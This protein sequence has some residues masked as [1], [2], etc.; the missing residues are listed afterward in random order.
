MISITGIILIL[1]IVMV[2]AAIKG[3]IDAPRKSIY[4]ARKSR[5][6]TGRSL[7]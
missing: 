7:L 3:W 4:V 1:G 5:P 6:L 2:T